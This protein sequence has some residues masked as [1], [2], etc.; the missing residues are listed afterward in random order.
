MRITCPTEVSTSPLIIPACL[1]VG[2]FINNSYPEMVRQALEWLRIA[3]EDIKTVAYEDAIRANA[4][5]GTNTT[6]AIQYGAY[7]DYFNNITL[8]TVGYRARRH[9]NPEAPLHVYV[10]YWLPYA[11]VQDLRDT[12]FDGVRTVMDMDKAPAWFLNEMRK[13]NLVVTFQYLK[14]TGVAA[15]QWTDQ[16]QTDAAAINKFPTSV[17]TTISAPGVWNRGV[18]MDVDFGMIVDSPL[19]RTNDVMFFMETMVAIF[20]R[21]LDAT[22]LITSTLCYSGATAGSITP[23]CG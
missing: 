18:I 17:E 2:N 1:T 6:S 4:I 12:A 15:T 20:P 16:A 19:I 10:P 8:A 7:R 22:E 11:L 21:C 14:P 5:A 23:T 3:Y 9:M 13:L